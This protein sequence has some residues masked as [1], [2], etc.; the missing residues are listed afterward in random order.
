MTGIY[1]CH[2]SS[3]RSM[4]PDRSLPG[5]TSRSDAAPDLPRE[6]RICPCIGIPF[7]CSLSGS[8][9]NVSMPAEI[10]EVWRIVQRAGIIRPLRPSGAALPCRIR[11][12]PPHQAGTF[13]P[14]P[15]PNLPGSRGTIRPVPLP[16]RAGWN[17]LRT[18]SFPPP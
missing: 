14:L 11:R 4:R 6:G 9:N 1:P 15:G 7:R 3:V 5:A 18:P 16:R 8:G 13:S 2:R 10:L 12:I 17:M